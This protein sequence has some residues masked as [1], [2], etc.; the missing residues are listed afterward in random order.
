MITLVQS[1][2]VGGAIFGTGAADLAFP[3]PVTAGT[4]MIAAIRMPGGVG[5]TITD[6]IGMAIWAEI[7]A[8]PD[9]VSTAI[10]AAVA[11]GGEQTITATI[12]GPN[13]FSGNLFGI[14]EYDG[15]DTGSMAFPP[16]NTALHVG[17]SVFPAGLV[18]PDTPNNVM[19]GIV[20]GGV[21]MW[22]LNGGYLTVFTNT[23]GGIGYRI[24]TAATPNN[25]T[26]SSLVNQTARSMAAVFPGLDSPPG[27]GGL[28]SRARY[29]HR[30]SWVTQ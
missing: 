5:V 8:D 27:S 21:D 26:P 25:F 3:A 22:T 30:A 17:V 9:T 10:W 1:A 20:A 7:A 24:Q 14:L 12:P 23:R 11:S 6:D 28:A 4:L 15:I 2:G 13:G 18:T 19:V 16:S 29:G